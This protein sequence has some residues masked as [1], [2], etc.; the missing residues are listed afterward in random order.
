MLQD[1][2]I[3]AGG[4]LFERQRVPKREWRLVHS[5]V[6]H[7]D[8]ESAPG[9]IYRHRPE[10]KEFIAAWQE[11]DAAVDSED[12]NLSWVRGTFIGGQ[13]RFYVGRSFISEI[14][15]K[16]E[17]RE[18]SKKRVDLAMATLL[19]VLAYRL[20]EIGL[21]EIATGPSGDAFFDAVVRVET[22]EEAAR[23]ARVI[24]IT[25]RELYV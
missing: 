7:L 4:Q 21:Y 22:P 17:R 13:W 20:R 23:A 6:K 18:I 11:F 1:Y 10:L 24:L 9:W 5:D 19:D 12:P 15:A 2:R 14:E 8:V 16:K 25:S 3:E